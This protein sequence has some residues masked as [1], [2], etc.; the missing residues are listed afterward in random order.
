MGA[1]DDFVY[2]QEFLESTGV[3]TPT[4]LWDASS[5]TWR[6]FGIRINSQMVV[7][8]ADLT[9]GS[10]VFYGFGESQQ[11]QVIAALPQLS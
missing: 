5:E 8:S 6:A 7:M 4:M 9:T 10:E 3:E 1:Q 11:Q 2:A